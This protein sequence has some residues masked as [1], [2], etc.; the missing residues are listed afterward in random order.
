ML[1]AVPRLQFNPARSRAPRSLGVV[2]LTALLGVPGCHLLFG[3]F[4]MVPLEDG[5]ANTGG[6]GVGSCNLDEYRCIGAELH[7]CDGTNWVLV[8]VCDQVSLCSSTEKRCDTCAA[9]QQKCRDDNLAIL[10]CNAQQNGWTTTTTCSGGLHCEVVGEAP[11]TRLGCA[12]CRSKEAHCGGTNGQGQP[13]ISTCSDDQ[14]SYLQS[15]CMVVPNCHTTSNGTD[16][17]FQCV[18]G[19]TNCSDDSRLLFTCNADG[20]WDTAGCPTQCV[21]SAAGIASCR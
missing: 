5:S 2:A 15:A 19:E 12:L 20:D 14:L 8:Q 10:T 6:T 3:D 21:K 1:T 4:E 11:N 7:R 16:Y 18:P 9:N 17:C 13:L